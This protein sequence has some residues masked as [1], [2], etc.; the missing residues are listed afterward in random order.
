MRA[1]A[2]SCTLNPTPATSNTEA[3]THV[4]LDALGRQGVETELIRVVDHD[5]RPGVESDMGDGDE[6]PAIRQRIVTSE[7]LVL[8]S[9]T[10]LGKPSSVAQRVLER[11]DAMLGETDDAGRPV[12]YNRVAGC[13]VTGNEDGAHHVITEIAGGLIDMGFTV[14]GQSWTYWNKGPGPGP[15][16][17]D[18]E[19]GHDWSHST[20]RAAA[21][22]LLAVA[23]ALRQSPM[24]PPPG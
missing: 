5:V 10:W 4:L 20:A 15:S 18:S 2:L 6:W 21:A 7:I 22:N 8:A 24:A 16:Y 3:L 23:R 17:L 1:V 9:P 14:P 19:E 13:V 12:A 11:M